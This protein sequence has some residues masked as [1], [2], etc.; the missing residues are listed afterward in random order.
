MR[1]I[2]ISFLK[3]ILN[4]AG[5][6]FTMHIPDSWPRQAALAANG[7]WETLEKLQDELQGGR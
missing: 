4:D 3:K 5:P 7:D 6:R 2:S 1:L